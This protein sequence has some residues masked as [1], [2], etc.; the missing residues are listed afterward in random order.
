MCCNR[1]TRCTGLPERDNSCVSPGKRTITTGFFRY[2][3]ARN[4]C[5]PPAPGGVRKSDS[6]SISING[7]VILSTYVIGDRSLKSASC[8][9][10]APRNQK[11]VNRV[12]SAVYQKSRQSAMDRCETAVLKRVVCPT[13]QLVSTPPPLPPVTPS[14]SG[15][16]QPRAISSSTPAIR[17]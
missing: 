15:S 14:L 7:V 1:S 2:F 10:G 3:S 12:K 5:S 9:Q 13:V 8:S 17:S 6:P 11:V 4:I 16:T